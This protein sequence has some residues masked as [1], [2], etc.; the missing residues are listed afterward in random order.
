MDKRHFRTTRRERAKHGPSRGLQATS[1]RRRRSAGAR[2]AQAGFGLD[3]DCHRTDRG[4]RRPVAARS[5]SGL[6]R[7]NHRLHDPSARR[8]PGGPG[9][10]PAFGRHGAGGMPDRGLVPGD[11]QQRLEAGDAPRSQRRGDLQLHR[12][13]PVLRLDGRLPARRAGATGRGRLGAVPV[14]RAHRRDRRTVADRQ[15]TGP[16]HALDDRRD[17]PHHPSE[18]RPAPVLGRAGRSQRFRR[19]RLPSP[20]RPG[21]CAVR[22]PS[23]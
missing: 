7:R 8:H 4:R 2:A 22:L 13:R 23:G 6:L 10:G 9:G 1:G 3:P 17:R 11:R 14:Q 12:G 16:R 15:R 20:R 21:P 18:Q 19:R 5:R